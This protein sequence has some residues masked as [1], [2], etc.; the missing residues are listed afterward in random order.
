MRAFLYFDL[1]VSSKP[2]VS[3][4]LGHTLDVLLSVRRFL[5]AICVKEELAVSGLV[6]AFLVAVSVTE[7][8]N[9]LLKNKLRSLGVVFNLANDLCHS[10]NIL[11]VNS[12]CGDYYITF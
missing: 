11:S 8:T 6:E 9:S 10:Y 5:A 1:R 7:V 2:F 4:Y 3:L 12:Y